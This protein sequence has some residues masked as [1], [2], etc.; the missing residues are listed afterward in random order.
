M[1]K[2]QIDLLADYIIAEVPGEP[3][4]NEG[5]GNTAIRIITTLK[6]QL[7]RLQKIVD[8]QAEDE[9]LWFQAQT[10]PEAYLQ[11]EL[12]KLHAD[13]EKGLG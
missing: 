3:S 1:S 2:T 4:Q 6:A 7:E 9:G 12:R 11:Q 10:A 5:A 13:I 8:T